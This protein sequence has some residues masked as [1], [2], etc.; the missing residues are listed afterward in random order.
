MVVS[1][2][3]EI[4]F[5]TSISWPALTAN[6]YGRNV[7]QTLSYKS[8]KSDHSSLSSSEVKNSC[9][10]Y[11]HSPFTTHGADISYDGGRLFLTLGL[12]WWILG[13]L[14]TGTSGGKK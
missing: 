9:S 6:A 5:C 12:A 4:F 2:L 7:P 10:F 11:Q 8:V 1:R 3:R 13:A 14:S